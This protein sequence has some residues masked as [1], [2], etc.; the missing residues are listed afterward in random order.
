MGCPRCAGTPGWLPRRRHTPTREAAAC[1]ATCRRK[2]EARNA[3]CM[4]YVDA[5]HIAHVQCACRCKWGHSSGNDLGRAR[6][7]ESIVR[8]AGCRAWGADAVLRRTQ[9]LLPGRGRHACV[10][11]N[12]LAHCQGPTVAAHNPNPTSFCLQFANS[13]PPIV[14]RGMDPCSYATWALYLE[15]TV[16]GHP[17]CVMGHKLG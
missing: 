12:P 7:G 2:A 8:W 9:N 17:F 13:L 11:L 1:A 16:G 15:V 6:A 14:Y 10:C 3:G 5:A 4:Q